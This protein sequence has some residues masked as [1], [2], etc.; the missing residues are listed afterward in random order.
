M[1]ATEETIAGV[2]EGTM[3]ALSHFDLERLLT[4]EERM[5]LLAR[6]EKSMNISPSLLESRNR[7]GRAL[8]ETRC[9]LDVLQRLRSRK[10]E[11]LWER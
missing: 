10:S 9:N 7:L 8:E 6:S 11:D 2:L 5:M 1:T 3:E 4:L